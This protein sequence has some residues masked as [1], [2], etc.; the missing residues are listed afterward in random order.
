MRGVYLGMR[1]SLVLPLGVNIHGIREVR[2]HNF[3]IRGF[4]QTAPSKSVQCGR[5]SCCRSNSGPR[6][7]LVT[8]LAKWLMSF[9]VMS[10]HVFHFLSSVLVSCCDRSPPVMLS[11][12]VSVRVMSCCDSV[13]L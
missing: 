1:C 6:E 4:K 5:Y 8:Y 13:M 10:C 12:A 9:H 11:L 2:C 7:K 3:K